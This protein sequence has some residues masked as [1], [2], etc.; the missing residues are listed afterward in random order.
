MLTYMFPGQG[1]QVKG[2]GRDL[3]NHFPELEKLADTILGYSIA[4]L[5]LVDPQRRLHITRYTQPALYV[6]NSLSYRLMRQQGAAPPDFLIGH[7]LGEYN[8][9]EASG[10]FSFEDGLRLVKKRGELM[11]E[12]P[13]GAMAAVLGIEAE[14]I[15]EIL[16]KNGYESIDIANRNAPEQTILSGLKEDIFKAE[17]LFQHG[18]VKYLPVNARGAFHSRYMQEAKQQ[19]LGTLQQYQF[20]NLNIPVISNLHARPY[21]PD[22][23]AKTLAEQITSPVNWLESIRY[24]MRVGDQ[25]AEDM[26]FQ[27]AGVGS[28]LTKMMESIQRN[29][30][31]SITNEPEREITPSASQSDPRSV[32]NALDG[33][34]I[35][36]QVSRWNKAYRTGTRVSVKGYTQQ[37]E[38]RTEAV[39]L[40]GHRAAIYMKGYEGYFSLDEVTAL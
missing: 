16:D 39:V 37:L 21:E 38:T 40:F 5:C 4:E 35:Y 11:D 23:I 29:S 34:D 13:P 33:E 12:A 19:F 28:V 25:R 26:R 3:F 1:S 15:R 8:A 9:L 18:E 30:Q 27:E 32:M 10:A 6:V 14:R 22:D 2:M 17:A 36:Q 24:L 20:S 31:Q 7:S